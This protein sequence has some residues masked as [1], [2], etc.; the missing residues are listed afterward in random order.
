ML[1]SQKVWVDKLRAN[2]LDILEIVKTY[3]PWYGRKEHK[4]TITATRAEVVSEIFRR[5]IEEKVKNDID[6]CEQIKLAIAAPTEPGLI[7]MLN[8][9][10]GAWLG[11]PESMESRQVKGFGLLCHLCEGWSDED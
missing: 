9:L 11:L 3:H 4:G 5:Q 6:P 8:I 1:T 7:I 2:Q 10:K